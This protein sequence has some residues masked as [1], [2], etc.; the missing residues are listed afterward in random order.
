M[1][2]PTQ[3]EKAMYDHLKEVQEYAERFARHHG[4]PYRRH[5]L[6]EIRKALIADYEQQFKPRGIEE[7]DAAIAALNALRRELV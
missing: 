1:R 4:I 3:L 2:L 7:I 5:H 6:Q